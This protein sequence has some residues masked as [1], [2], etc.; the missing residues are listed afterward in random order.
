MP[1]VVHPFSSVAGAIAAI[2]RLPTRTSVLELVI[3]VLLE[4]GE[5]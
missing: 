1:G 3:A 5:G 4:I 2:R